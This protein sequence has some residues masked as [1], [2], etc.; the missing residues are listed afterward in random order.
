MYNTVD[1]YEMLKQCF[2]VM[3]PNANKVA[4]M[5]S[6]KSRSSLKQMCHVQENV[7]ELDAVVS[8]LMIPLQRQS[9]LSIAFHCDK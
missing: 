4:L 6:Y 7:T 8:V 9:R 5:T 2:L 3:L 1:A